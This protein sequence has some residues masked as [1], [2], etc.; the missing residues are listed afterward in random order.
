MSTCVTFII[1]QVFSHTDFHFILETT[2]QVGI[3]TTCQ[4]HFPCGPRCGPRFGLVPLLAQGSTQMSLPKK[5]HPD[6]SCKMSAP[7]QSQSP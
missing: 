7:L 3:I 6:N 2:L 5:G 1:Y 4:G